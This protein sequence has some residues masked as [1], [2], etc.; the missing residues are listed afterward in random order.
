MFST[1]FAVSRTGIGCRVWKLFIVGDL[2]FPC[3]ETH[4]KV[5]APSAIS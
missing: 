2:P 5:M 1:T 4:C 3:D